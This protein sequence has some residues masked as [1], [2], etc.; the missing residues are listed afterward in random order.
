M[1]PPGLDG[2]YFRFPP[3]GKETLPWT[4][5]IT[6]SA[7]TAAGIAGMA[8]TAVGTGMGIAGTIGGFSNIPR[9][10]KTPIIAMAT[11]VVTTASACMMQSF[12][13]KSR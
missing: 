3:F 9:A 2:K 4:A 6:G 1:W 11:K 10:I 7:W 12:A 5:G 13:L 8:G